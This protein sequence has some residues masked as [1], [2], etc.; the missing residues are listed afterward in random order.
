MQPNHVDHD[1]QDN[2]KEDRKK[3][4]RNKGSF[5]FFNST[6]CVRIQILAL[7]FFVGLFLFMCFYKNHACQMGNGASEAEI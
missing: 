2:K 6:R 5:F 4:Y 1:A 7:V 3:I